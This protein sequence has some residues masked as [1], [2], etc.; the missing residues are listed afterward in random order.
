MADTNSIPFLYLYTNR[1]SCWSVS[2]KDIDKMTMRFKHSLLCF[3]FLLISFPIFADDIVSTSV[4][5]KSGEYL[6]Y[7]NKTTGDK[8]A[9]MKK[10]PS[11]KGWVL[12]PNYFPLDDSSQA[13][14]I[15]FSRTAPAD[16]FPKGYY[17]VR[18]LLN[19]CFENESYDEVSAVSSDL[20]EVEAD[21]FHN[22]K[23]SILR[24]HN[25]GNSA[26]QGT[27]DN[28]IFKTI[29]K[30]V[31]YHINADY[32]FIADAQ[33]EAWKSD[34]LWG[35]DD[36]IRCTNYKNGE[37]SY[38]PIELDYSQQPTVRAANE[39]STLY[40]NKVGNQYWEF[41]NNG[42]STWTKVDSHKSYFTDNNPQKGVAFYRALTKSGSYIDF[43]INYYDR[44]PSTVNIIANQEEFT[45]EDTVVLKLDMNVDDCTYQW[46]KDGEAIFGNVDAT[47]STF[48]IPGVMAVDAGT[49]CCVITNP[50]GRVIS[51]TYNLKVNRCEQKLPEIDLGEITYTPNKRIYL[52]AYTDKKRQITYTSSNENIASI[53]YGTIIAVKTAGTVTIIASQ[54]GSND[55][56]PIGS[57]PY[58]LII[59]KATQEIPPFNLNE[60]EYSTWG[61]VALKDSLSSVGLPLTYTSSNPEVAEVEYSPKTGHWTFHT[62]GIGETTITASQNGN[63]CYAAATPVSSKLVVK[64]KSQKYDPQFSGTISYKQKAI[65][66]SKSSLH[67]PMKLTSNDKS[68][69]V[70][71]NDS[72][73]GVHP[74][75]T[76]IHYS[77]AGDQYTESIDGEFEI[78]VIKATNEIRNDYIVEQYSEEPY[79]MNIMLSS[80]QEYT[81]T[82]SDENVVAPLYKDYV[83]FNSAGTATITIELAENEFY[84]YN[85][86]RIDFKINRA[87]QSIS[88]NCP[89]S[90]V[91]TG[92]EIRYK[93][94]DLASAKTAI[95]CYSLDPS[96]ISVEGDEIV[97]HKLGRARLAFVA[98]GNDK[99]DEAN[100]VVI[101]VN[102]VSNAEN[103]VDTTKSINIDTDNHKVVLTNL[104][105]CEISSVTELTLSQSGYANQEPV[106]SVTMPDGTLV[107]FAKSNGQNTPRYYTNTGGIRVYANNIIQFYPKDESEEISR[108]TLYCDGSYLGNKAATFNCGAAGSLDYKN[109]IEGNTAGTQLRIKKIRIEYTKDLITGIRKNILTE[110]SN[111]IMRIYSI[112]GQ[113]RNKIEQGFNI[114]VYKNGRRKKIY[115]K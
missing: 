49:Y 56:S 46:Y 11:T 70:I 82:S 10:H 29:T 39:P 51:T 48:S 76:T 32:V 35:N 1:R 55:Y 22:T 102:V 109:Y 107:T 61:S 64:K 115:C 9:E 18:K 38:E 68:I 30:P 94:A 3:L 69:A 47:S 62:C 91:Y 7:Y 23:V 21:A 43:K 83:R 80:E 96:V 108:I 93:V 60:E 95:T 97:I 112:D 101:E 19:G 71:M 14:S 31:P 12:V 113:K 105:N 98:T 44:I 73:F 36:L 58:K 59:H 17:H 33:Y 67:R 92:K 114:I 54:T 88:V 84:N 16:D 8:W 57:T 34:K 77:E 86:A 15:D 81:I 50:V 53:E 41:S 65:I 20:K 111:D 89:T 2:A 52:P 45:A 87:P 79:C 90:F 78:T 103:K 110:I 85:K 24:F 99:Y 106:N 42:G 25:V 72:I 100:D 63:D 104:S 28:V 66:N 13:M 5:W 74:G 75:I 6:L 40:T 4:T 27:E 26:W 37:H